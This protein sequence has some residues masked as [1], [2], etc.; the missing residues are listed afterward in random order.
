MKKFNGVILANMLTSSKLPTEGVTVVKREAEFKNMYSA[1]FYENDCPNTFY[2]VTGL[3]SSLDRKFSFM[4]S[5][6]TFSHHLTPMENEIECMEVKPY[7]EIITRY[8][9]VR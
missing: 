1:V 9:Y 4:N 8:K 5:D 6:A 3:W 7:E 2:R